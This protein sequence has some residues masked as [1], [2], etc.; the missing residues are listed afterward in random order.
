MSTAMRALLDGLV[1]YAGLFPPAG[2]AM[3][4]AV[5]NYAAYRRGQTRGM[6]ARFVVPAARLEEFTAEATARRSADDKPW[7]LA[8]LA[9]VDDA[10]TLDAFERAQRGAF[11]IDTIEAKAESVA[12]IVR[13]ARGLAGRVVYVEIPIREDPSV[14]IAALKANG[15]RAK[16]RTGGV[17][18]EAFPN[19]DD[20]MRFLAACVTRQLPFK[21]TA[22]LHHPLRG[23]YALT[24]AA[25]AARGEMYGFLNVFLS[26]AFLLAGYDAATVAPLLVERDA[27]QL[28]VSGE[29]IRWRTLHVDQ[30]QL[31]AARRLAGSFGS[32]SFDEPVQD[33][34]ALSLLPDFP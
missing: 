15:L 28:Q 25:D 34:A 11:V 3:S 22:G 10:A 19:P 7:P 5:R 29:Q 27:S 20:L 23:D 2:L 9:A 26:A 8:V 18:A 31:R 12:D 4:D 14:L 24:Y 17:T 16:V 21:A 6:L 1:D 13:I 33:L 32:C 30:D